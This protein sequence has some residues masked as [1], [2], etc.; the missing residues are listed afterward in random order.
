MGSKDKERPQTT[1]RRTSIDADLFEVPN[2]QEQSIIIQY[3][4]ELAIATN[5]LL[6]SKTILHPRKA[7]VK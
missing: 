1:S 2:S 3:F 5:E 4:K 7:E 6:W